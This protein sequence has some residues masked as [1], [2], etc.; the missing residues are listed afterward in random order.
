MPQHA[1]IHPQASKQL[2][3]KR[4]SNSKRIKHTNARTTNLLKTILSRNTFRNWTWR[5]SW[6]ISTRGRRR[7]GTV[8]WTIRTQTSIREYIIIRRNTTTSLWRRRWKSLETH[9]RRTS[10]WKSFRM[11]ERRA[12]SGTCRRRN[13]F[14]VGILIEKFFIVGR[15]KAVVFHR[16]L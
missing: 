13:R 15:I 5:S 4:T 6:L 11:T 1:A 12:T 14:G 16:F 3:S 8:K 2:F 9:I 10:F 7:F